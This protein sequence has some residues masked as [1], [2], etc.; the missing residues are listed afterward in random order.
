MDLFSPLSVNGR[1]FAIDSNLFVDA[2]RRGDL[3]S[4][5]RITAKYENDYGAQ[6]RL[7]SYEHSSPVGKLTTA[8]QAAAF[9]GH[10]HVIKFLFE[11]YPLDIDGRDE[12]RV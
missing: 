1:Q 3:N 10:V 12:V 6:L 5:R 11:E 8:F 9:N 7:V 4:I 2:A